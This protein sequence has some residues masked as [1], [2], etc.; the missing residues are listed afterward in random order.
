M[1]PL[2]IA[3]A[4][5]VAGS[6]AVIGWLLL[7]PRDRTRE[8]VLANAAH[9]LS[10]TAADAVGAG[11]AGAGL[12]HP[13]ALAKRVAPPRM[14]ARLDRLWALAGRPRAWNP[15]RLFL[16]KLVLPLVV[17][18]LGVLFVAA[19]PAPA[20]VLLAAVVTVGVFFVPDLL[21][22]SRGQERQKK[23]ATELPDTMDQMTIAVEAGLGFEAAM[24]RTVKNGRG[25]LAAE[26]GRTL[27]DMQIGRSRREAYLALSDR[28]T[29]SELRRF[30]RAVVQADIYGIAIA[31]VLRTQAAEM[32][33]KRRQRAEEQA[34]KIP[35][36]V[37]F[38]LMLCILPALF[39]V[40]LGPA[41][42]DIMKAFGGM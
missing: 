11:L 29:V 37:I 31:D 28:T 6:A 10:A 41:V 7:A 42:I 32:R 14:M 22:Q 3:A 33:I 38:P 13:V 36:K 2:M 5:A 21:L 12:A 1:P 8:Q 27:Q 16:I 19:G 40:L 39:I 35:V 18:L 15:E 9:G 34:M 20:R 17:G 26:L 4:V 24:Q 30:V 23:I 25:P